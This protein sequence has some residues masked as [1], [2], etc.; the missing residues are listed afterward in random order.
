MRAAELLLQLGD[1]VQARLVA[2]KALRLFESIGDEGTHLLAACSVLA[3]V[4]ENEKLH[5][6][7]IRLFRRCLDGYCVSGKA[8]WL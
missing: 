8:T 1:T 5:E 2:T 3:R 6:E 7:A 4:C